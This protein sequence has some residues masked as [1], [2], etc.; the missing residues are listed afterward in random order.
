MLWDTLENLNMVCIG[1]G[2][3]ESTAENR[4]ERL[5]RRLGSVLEQGFLLLGGSSGSGRGVA[6]TGA[7]RQRGVQGW[8]HRDGDEDTGM[9]TREW[10]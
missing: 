3:S 8:G 4:W 1:I 6:G 2:V 5:L 10:G 7:K 9:G